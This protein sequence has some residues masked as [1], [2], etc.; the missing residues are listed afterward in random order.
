MSA[1]D[2]I[3][4][5]RDRILA[6]DEPTQKELQAVLASFRADREAAS[7]KTV[8]KKEAKAKAIASI[9]ANLNDLFKTPEKK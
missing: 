7:H 1:T 9:P 4:D 6:G 2:K 8:A 3:N 5:M